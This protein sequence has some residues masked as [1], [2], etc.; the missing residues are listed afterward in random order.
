MLPKC[1]S[2]CP[3]G[4][5]FCGG[6]GAAARVARHRAA[7]ARSTRRRRSRSAGAP[8]A[9]AG[10]GASG[11][12]RPPMAAR[13]SSARRGHAAGGHARSIRST[14][15][16]RV[17]GEGGMG[18]VYLARDIHTGLDV[19]LKADPQRA[20]APRRRPRSARSPRGAPS[21]RSITPTSSISRR[22]SST[23]TSLWLV[24]QYIDGESLDK[25]IAGYAA[26]HERM[27]VDR[28]ARHLPADC[29]AASPPRT[30]R[31]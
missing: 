13:R 2:S 16:D 14:P 29:L 24:M 6:C 17:L 18:V 22:W 30:T 10:R 4:A 12:R 21:R 1:G 20:R 5:V 23:G 19:V 26:R 3:D 31:A 11:W 7:A 8:P 15:I 9:A 25:T 28:G 27:P